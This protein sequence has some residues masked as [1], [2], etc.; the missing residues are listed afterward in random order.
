MTLL[1]LLGAAVPAVLAEDRNLRVAWSDQVPYQYLDQ[2]DKRD[3]PTGIDLEVMREAARRAGLTMTFRYHPFGESLDLLARGD[4]DAV[5]GAYDSAER[6]AFTEVSV[7]YR[8]GLDRIF[9]PPDLLLEQTGSLAD[10]VAQFRQQRL[11]LAVVADFDWGEAGRA[12]IDALR[13]DGLVVDTDSLPQ[14]ISMVL[15]GRADAFVGDQLSGLALLSIWNAP[16]I[17][18]LPVVVQERGI[19][20]LFARDRLPAWKIQRFDAA[21][22]DMLDDGTVDRILQRFTNPLA[23]DAVFHGRTVELLF[24]IGIIAFSISGIVIARQGNYS[25]FGAFVLASLPALGGGVLRDVLLLR[26]LF[27]FESP[28]MIYTCLV[29]ILMGYLF[30]RFLRAVRGRALWFFD[31]VNFFVRLRRRMNP[32]LALE[33]FDAIGLALFTVVAISITAEEGLAPLWFWGPLIGALTATGGAIM[34]DMIR[35]EA[36][37]PILHTSFYGETAFLWGMLLAVFLQFAGP[38]ASTDQILVAVIVC[39]LGIVLTRMSFV[40]FRIPTPRY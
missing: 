35:S 38:Y 31:L 37:N 8:L 3:A 22:Q 15:G 28:E 17:A 13:A 32:R 2:S 20:I 30:N 27:F 39:V 19:H 26:K 40:L 25:I 24:I 4:I 9:A 16:Q 18:A 14:S 21:L 7:P 33:F 1:L 5:V 23:I 11:R 6:R 12:A 29:T 10:V 34:R 36:H